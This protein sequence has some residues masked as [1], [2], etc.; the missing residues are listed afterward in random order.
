MHEVE[1]VLV[2]PICNCAIRLHGTV[3]IRNRINWQFI[4]CH[5]LLIVSYDCTIMLLS[6]IVARAA[7]ALW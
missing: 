3:G 6:I 5:M 2:S 7:A 4:T 1:T